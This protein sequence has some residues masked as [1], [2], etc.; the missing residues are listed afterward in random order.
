LFCDT[1]R[2]NIDKRLRLLEARAATVVYESEAAAVE[3]IAEA[4]VRV[5][6]TSAGNSILTSWAL[7]ED[8]YAANPRF[9][10]RRQVGT[11]TIGH[12]VKA[13]SERAE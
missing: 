4:T 12:G 8:Q 13:T 3:R 6:T 11:S 1:V 2:N 5:C 10:C 7:L 9:C